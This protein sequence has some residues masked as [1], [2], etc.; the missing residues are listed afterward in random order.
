MLGPLFGREARAF[1]RTFSIIRRT[2]PET[3]SALKPSSPRQQ[4][5]PCRRLDG[6]VP[7]RRPRT[8]NP[9]MPA[10]PFPH[11]PCGVCDRD[12]V[13]GTN[14]RQPPGRCR[15][16]AEHHDLVGQNAQRVTRRFDSARL[17]SSRA[18]VTLVAGSGSRSR[19]PHHWLVSGYASSRR[20]Q[21]RL[22]PSPEKRVR[23]AVREVPWEA[24]LT[25]TPP[26]GAVLLQ[27]SHTPNTTARSLGNLPA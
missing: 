19:A 23:P 10:P 13:Q 3:P 25:P 11:L 22:L 18:H 1:P 26:S 7:R 20:Q 12:R 16:V 24:E 15:G 2:G 5:L 8:C 27:T 6:M 17:R 9:D 21:G 14:T 4:P